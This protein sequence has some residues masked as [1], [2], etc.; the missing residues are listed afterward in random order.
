M[1]DAI[2]I[3]YMT[4]ANDAEAT[5]LAR[6]LVQEKLAGCVNILGASKSFYVWQGALNESAEVLP[7]PSH[8]I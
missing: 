3:V 4:A 1:A 6:T 7:G 8:K 2:H 5:V